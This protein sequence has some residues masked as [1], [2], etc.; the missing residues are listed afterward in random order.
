[1]HA[2]G[3]HHACVHARTNT[4]THQ[5]THS[6]MRTCV[7]TRKRTHA[8]TL[9]CMYACRARSTHIRCTHAAHAEVNHTSMHATQ[10]CT[11]IRMHARTIARSTRNACSQA[12]MHAGTHGCS[13][14]HG[15]HTHTARSRDAMR[16][17]TVKCHARHP[18]SLEGP[19]TH[20][21]HVSCL[22]LL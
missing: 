5:H 4:P 20:I 7:H 11:R 22:L 8:R 6:P 3:V 21:S 14:A 10:V 15:A 16:A 9:T 13:H 17:C 1:M 18:I 2:R 12:C 19:S